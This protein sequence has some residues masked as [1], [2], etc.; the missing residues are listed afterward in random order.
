MI[1]CLYPTEKQQNIIHRDFMKSQVGAFSDVL[2]TFQ[3][4]NTLETVTGG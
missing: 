1:P 2:N 4:E 3:I